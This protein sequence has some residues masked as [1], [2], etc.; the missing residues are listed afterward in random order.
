MKNTQVIFRDFV[1][2]LPQ[3]SD[4]IVSSSSIRL[5]LPEASNGVLLKT[6]YLSC[7][8]FMRFLMESRPPSTSYSPGS[9]ISFPLLYDFFFRPSRYV[10]DRMR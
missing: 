7:D 6:L 2:G 3:E 8:P 1:S 10:L 4:F 9:V 5:K